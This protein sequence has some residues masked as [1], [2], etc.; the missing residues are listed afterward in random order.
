M[1]IDPGKVTGVARG[2]FSAGMEAGMRDAFASVVELETWEV[3]GP[4]PV[5]AWEICA[6]FGDWVHGLVKSGVVMAGSMSEEV[7]LCIEDFRLRTQNV[8][9]DPVMVMSGITTL[10]VPRAAGL[11]G[12]LGVS[13]QGGVGMGRY[14]LGAGVYF[15]Q[16]AD[17]MRFATGERLEEW[18]GRRRMLRVCGGGAGKGGGRVSEHRRDALRHLCFRLGVVMTERGGAVSVKAAPLGSSDNPVVRK[19]RTR[20]WAA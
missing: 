9:L 8:D 16:P 6:E 5:Q 7:A 14:A 10:L 3:E 1:A 2:I 12:E 15:Q 20:P 13:G 4:H 19:G 11:R 18:L 17:A